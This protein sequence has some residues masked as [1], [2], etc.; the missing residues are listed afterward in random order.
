MT[1][2]RQNLEASYQTNPALDPKF[3]PSRLKVQ[4][5]VDISERLMHLGIPNP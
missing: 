1:S 5:T 3:S 4:A 2:K